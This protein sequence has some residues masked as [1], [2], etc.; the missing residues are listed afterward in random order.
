MKPTGIVRRIDHLGR[1]VLPIEWRR[2]FGIRE[3]DPMEIF[4][5]GEKI[6]LKKYSPVCTFCGFPGE[7]TRFK[8]KPIC[9][10]CKEELLATAV[11]D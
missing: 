4:V 10:H 2:I 9:W 6:V 8:G 5:D 7:L 1:V 11:V 3:N